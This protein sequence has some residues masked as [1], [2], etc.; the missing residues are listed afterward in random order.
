VKIFSEIMPRMGTR[1]SRVA[2]GRL[3]SGGREECNQRS[4]KVEVLLC[5]V[6]YLM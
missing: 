2:P 6:G 3:G 5:S 4:G 1:D